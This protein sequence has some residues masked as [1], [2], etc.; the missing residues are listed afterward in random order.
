MSCFFLQAG[1]ELR[2]VLVDASH[3]VAGAQPP[4]QSS[5]VPGRASGELVLFEKNNVAPTKLC[6]VI[7]DAA[8]NH[9]AAN[10]DNFCFSRDSGAHCG[11]LRRNE[12]SRQHST[13]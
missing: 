3:A 11:T 2:T 1:I 6:Q 7:G 9:A 4:N 8:A 5:R 10:D 13:P 12:T